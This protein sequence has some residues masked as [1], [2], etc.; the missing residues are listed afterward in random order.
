MQKF[1]PVDLSVNTYSYEQL[2]E[3]KA[4]GFDVQEQIDMYDRG[5]HP[6]QIKQAAEAKQNQLEEQLY[7]LRFKEVSEL[8]INAS[9]IPNPTD[10]SKVS[11][12]LSTKIDPNSA[13]VIESLKGHKMDQ[14]E[15]RQGHMKL[16][17]IVQAAPAFWSSEGEISYAAL[18]FTMVKEGEFAN[19]TLFLKLI[20]GML[21]NFRD[22]DQCPEGLTPE[23]QKLYKD[24]NNPN[25]DF[26][27]HVDQS[28]LDF[29][30]V[31]FEGKPLITDKI[32]V[33]TTNKTQSEKDILPKKCFPTDGIVPLLCFCQKGRKKDYYY[34]RFIAGKYYS[35]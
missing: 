17:S 15:L 20:S 4:Q 16:S 7:L 12:Y 11:S 34:Y 30:Q 31:S 18:V 24:L 1:T 2:I 22:E 35:A 21:N 8:E 32:I 33:A 23:M 9:D 5:E 6:N 3:M 26:H 13:L 27:T 29:Y 14:E 10:M 19:N 28:L 25:S